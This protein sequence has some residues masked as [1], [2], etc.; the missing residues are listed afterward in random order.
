[1][2]SLLKISDAPKSVVDIII[3]KNIK[4]MVEIGVYRSSF[5]KQILKTVGDR[6]DCYWLVDPW[7]IDHCTDG[8]GS[9]FTQDQW[10]NEYI[11]A[12][13]LMFDYGCVKVLRMTSVK[14]ASLFAFQ[15]VDL[16]YIDGSHEYLDL[17]VDIGKW[18]PKIKSGGV[19]SGHDYSH[20]WPNVVMAVDDYF[21]KGK[22]Q[23]HR[24]TVW[25]VTIK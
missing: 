23:L 22:I 11:N 6:L 25:S 20:G 3:R 16:V 10:E 8:S 7:D 9:S 19:I 12:C 13:R 15:S 21:G 1:M 24:G 18:M 4:T 17:T 14:A 2:K 5:C